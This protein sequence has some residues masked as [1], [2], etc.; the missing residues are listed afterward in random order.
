MDVDQEDLVYP[1]KGKMFEYLVSLEVSDSSTFANGGAI[2]KF[3]LGIS[4]F[5]EQNV[6]HLFSCSVV[7]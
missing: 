4:W 5:N 3:V 1:N 6:L 7:L 2:P